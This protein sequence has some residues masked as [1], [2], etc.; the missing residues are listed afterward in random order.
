MVRN[1]GVYRVGNDR[2]LV[3]RERDLY[4]FAVGKPE[5]RLTKLCV[6][7]DGEGTEPGRGPAGITFGSMRLVTDRSGRLDVWTDQWGFVQPDIENVSGAK[8]M[9]ECGENE[10]QTQEIGMVPLFH[11]LSVTAT[12]SASCMPDCG[13]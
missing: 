7:V 12:G 8:P 11:Q 4:L 6:E 3:L 2:L 5:P 9:I 1:R 10:Y 13:D